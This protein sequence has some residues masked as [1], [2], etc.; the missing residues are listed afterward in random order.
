MAFAADWSYIRMSSIYG[1][2]KLGLSLNKSLDNCR[3]M[4]M[5]WTQKNPAKRHIYH[6]SL[7]TCVQKSALSCR[8]IT[9][10]S[11][12][13]SSSFLSRNGN[14]SKNSFL[15]QFVVS[16][17]PL[18]DL[19]FVLYFLFVCQDVFLLI[20]MGSEIDTRDIS[21]SFSQKRKLITLIIVLHLMCMH[22]I[23]TKP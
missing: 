13:L 20:L 18:R 8:L 1:K 11:S 10:T 14:G 19:S 5:T 22:V 23:Y 3:Y 15:T 9:A 6:L 12:S 2:I 21:L 7:Q 16:K 17:R 4:T